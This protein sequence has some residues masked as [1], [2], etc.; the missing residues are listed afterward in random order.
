[1]GIQEKKKLLNDPV[2]GFINI[3]RGVIYDVFE[4]KYFQ[5]LRRIKQLGMSHLVYPSAVHSRFSHAIGATFLMNEAINTIRQ[6]GTE[7]TNEEK[8]ASLLAILL[9]DIGHGPFSHALEYSIVKEVSHEKI[10]LLF[11]EQL[12]KEFDG[13]LSLAISIFKDEYPKRFLHQL[14]SSQLDVDRM[15]YLRRDSFFTGVTEGAIGTQR[16]I[17]ML[18]VVDGN[19]VIEHKGIYSIESFL[20][21]RRIMYWQ[22]YLHKTVLVAEHLLMNILK[23]A[24][25]VSKNGEKLF[26][27]PAFSYFLNNDV[28]DKLFDNDKIALQN[29]AL[30]D[31][32]DILSAIKT[33]AFNSKD[34]VLRDL[35]ER[36]INRH[37]FKIEYSDKEFSIA[38]LNKLRKLTQKQL[39]ISAEDISYYV[40]T[41]H[42]SNYMY[43]KEGGTID[44]LF[45]DGKVKD[46]A[47]VSEQLSV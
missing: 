8:E 46:I 14:V 2:Y 7:I 44:I 9:H 41:D 26:A 16:I 1:M 21:S 19:I 36:M 38:K 32:Y 17:K 29:Y 40:F 47:N 30:L 20:H 11:M 6:K 10:S 12:N 43:S 33:W 31:D 15:D 18:D 25:Y 28:D 3:P 5:R 39:N 35:S 13:K 37:F 42:T 4:H 45:K 23:R 22:V 27:T 34:S 24:K